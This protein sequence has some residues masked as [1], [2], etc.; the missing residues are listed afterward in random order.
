MLFLGFNPGSHV[1]IRM[2]KI[3]M[4]PAYA[5]KLIKRKNAEIKDILLREQETSRTRAF[6]EE[7]ISQFKQ[8]YSFFATQ[9]ELEQ[10]RQDILAL[11]HAINVFNV[12]T[13]LPELGY[14]IDVALVRMK[15]LTSHVEKLAT[16]MRVQPVTR[17]TVTFGNGKPEFVYR[18][19][20]DVEAR[21]AHEAASSELMKIQLA[22]DK[23][24]LE[25]VI[26]V[27]LSDDIMAVKPVGSID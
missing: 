23:A 12:N 15:M 4:S 27:E 19:Y 7:D 11:K 14:T 25:S 1:L 26:E 10:R 16:M 3:S 24:N 20:T 13:V 8:A 9:A 21:R 6:A 18:N 22:L 5:S 17:Q 2:K